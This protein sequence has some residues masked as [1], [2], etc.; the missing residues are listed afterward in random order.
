MNTRSDDDY[1]YQATRP[2]TVFGLALGAAAGAVVLVG[3]TWAGLEQASEERRLA[4]PP[5]LKGVVQSSADGSRAL[6]DN[7]TNEIGDRRRK[8]SDTN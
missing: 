1:R 6:L 3:A 5:D 7:V 2:L 4:P 8:D